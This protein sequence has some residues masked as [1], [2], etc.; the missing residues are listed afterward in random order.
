MA[1][2]P[3]PLGTLLRERLREAAD[4]ARAPGMQAYMK[5]AMPY[6][7]VPA[8]PLRKVCRAVFGGLS[9]TDSG[10]WQRDVLAIWR[11][12]AFR[13][14]RYAAIE[15]TG[16]RAA[17]AF[18]RLDALPLYEEMIVAAAFAAHP[19]PAAVLIGPEGGFDDAERELVRAHPQAR[20]IGL[21]PRI[22]RGETAAIAAAALWMGIAGDWA[23]DW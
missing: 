9:W 5:S 2:E 16:V 15:L 17:R 4:P 10:A 22:L 12:A 23:G 7:G 14:E 20:P 8:V 21:G 6:L 11:G 13:E 18:Q 1:A 3:A 19:G